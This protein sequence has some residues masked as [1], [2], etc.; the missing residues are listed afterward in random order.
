MKTTF[1]NFTSMSMAHIERR[2]L[3]PNCWLSILGMT[4]KAY[5]FSTKVSTGYKNQLG[6]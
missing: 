2:Q 6:M 4:K 5:M 1:N 3:K